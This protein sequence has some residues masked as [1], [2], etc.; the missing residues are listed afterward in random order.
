MASLSLS[1]RVIKCYLFVKALS[2]VAE[3]LLDAKFLNIKNVTFGETKLNYS[4]KKY[5]EYEEKLGD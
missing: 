3:I 4:V 2:D 5:K 1:S